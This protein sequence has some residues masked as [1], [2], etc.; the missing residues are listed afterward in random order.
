MLN[1]NTAA[2]CRILN[3]D[4]QKALLDWFATL[5]ER[6]ERKDDKRING[7]AWRAEL[8]RMAPPYGVM[9]CEGYD[10]LRQALTKHMRLQPLD[11]MALALF[12]SVAV[13]IKSHK[14]KISFAAQLGEKING[15]TPCVLGLRFE[16]LQKASDP[17]TFCQLLIQSVKIR[18]TNGVNVLS[19]A[20]SIFLWMEEWQRRENH[21][22]E[23]RNPFERN[24]TR[25]ANEYLSTSR[26]K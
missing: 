12:V 2:L 15:S 5:S 6:Y 9:M 1:S 20:D 25:W 3:P 8:K 19:L 10:A 4:A 11:E 26:G 13:H 21:Q 7:R 17:E 14:E 23:P 24:R 18:G 22:P 16:R